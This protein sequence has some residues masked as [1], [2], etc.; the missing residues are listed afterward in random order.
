METQ[1]VP[2]RFLA[3]CVAVENMETESIVIEGQQR[4]II[5]IAFTYTC[6]C[7]TRKISFGLV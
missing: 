1:R 2:F 4:F 3:T 6:R 7:Q 5:G